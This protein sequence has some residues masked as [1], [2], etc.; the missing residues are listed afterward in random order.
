MYF[1]LGSF[2]WQSLANRDEL[3]AVL[4]GFDVIY[5]DLHVG[6]YASNMIIWTIVSS[7]QLLFLFTPFV[8][9]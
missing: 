5:I 2:I 1:A 6:N 9:I 7:Y 4:V 8:H 3:N